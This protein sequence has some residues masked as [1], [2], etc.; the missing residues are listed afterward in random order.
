ME[1]FSV[2]LLTESDLDAI[3]TGAGGRRAHPDADRRTVP[4]ADY[5]LA[6]IVIEL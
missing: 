2:P 4:G 5:V 6:D 1:P 3:I